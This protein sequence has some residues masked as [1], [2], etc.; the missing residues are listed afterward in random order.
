[1]TQVPSTRN[2][3]VWPKPWTEGFVTGCI[4]WAHGKSAVG[5]SSLLSVWNPRQR[6]FTRPSWDGSFL[7]STTP[8]NQT[9]P[10][11]PIKWFCAM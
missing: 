3:G 6:T 7:S 4:I 11:S 2:E 5:I 10:S 1:M 8:V 9:N